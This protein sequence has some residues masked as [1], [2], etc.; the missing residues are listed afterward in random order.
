METKHSVEAFEGLAVEIGDL[1][2]AAKLGQDFGKS[3]E[4]G[5]L[6]G[7][8]GIPILLYE[9]TGSG[10]MHNYLYRANVY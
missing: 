4:P 3:R 5:G 9:R 6:G 7:H 2:E 8:G 1:F 10:T